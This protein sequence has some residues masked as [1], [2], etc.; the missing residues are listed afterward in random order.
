MLRDYDDLNWEPNNPSAP[1]N[2]FEEA[3]AEKSRR[4]KRGLE[5]LDI[6][7]NDLRVIILPNYLFILFL[8]YYFTL[9][10]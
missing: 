7:G 10:K 6:T 9:P 3:L 4:R 8:I 5:S 1:F 2:E